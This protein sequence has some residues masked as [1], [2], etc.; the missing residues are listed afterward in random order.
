MKTGEG[1]EHYQ[2]F[3]EQENIIIEI[4]SSVMQQNACSV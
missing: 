4:I 3:E 1:C 2:G